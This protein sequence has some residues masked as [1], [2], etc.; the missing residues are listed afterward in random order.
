MFVAPAAAPW[1][2]ENK[3]FMIVWGFMLGANDRQGSGGQ[4]EVEVAGE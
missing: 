2:F 1:E 3:E 4:L